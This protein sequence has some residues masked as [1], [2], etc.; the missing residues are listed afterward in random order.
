MRKLFPF[1]F[2][3]ILLSCTQDRVS[4][5]PNQVEG[6]SPVYASAV[7][8]NVI[9]FETAAR[10]TERAGKI[11][12]IGNYIFQNDVNKGIHIINNTNR[13]HPEKVGFI[14]LPFSNEIA[15]KGN[16]LYSNNLNDL[17]VFDI[18]DITKPKL[19]KRIQNVFPPVDQ[20]YPPIPN[21]SFE[22]PDASK[23]IVVNWERK[24]LTDP[25]CRR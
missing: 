14:K 13:S 9:T 8:V 17:V 4:S 2:P 22:C 10:P 6:Y 20:K 18:S 7:D 24:L 11:Y 25:K 19:V 3:L 1:F 15:V 5:L 16:Y 23:G 12:A 21:A